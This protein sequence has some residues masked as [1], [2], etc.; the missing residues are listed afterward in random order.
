MVGRARRD[1]EVGRI[2]SDFRGRR[3]RRTQLAQRDKGM[4]R[5]WPVVVEVEDDDFGQKR[6][7]MF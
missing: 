4:R 7:S 2:C 6:V 3:G 5:G 1:I